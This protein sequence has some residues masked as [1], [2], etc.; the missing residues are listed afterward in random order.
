GPAPRAR[1]SPGRASPCASGGRRR[2]RRMRGGAS[3]NRG[4]GTHG[5]RD[6]TDPA[7]LAL[8]IL[9]AFWPESLHDTIA[10]ELGLDLD[11]ISRLPATRMRD[12]SF[13]PA[14]LR[15]YERRC[16][17]CGF[18]AT[19]GD[20]LIGIDAAHIHFK[21]EGGPDVVTNGLALCSLHHKAFDLGAIGVSH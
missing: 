6:R 14:I 20:A 12:P 16:V 19:L 3:V 2:G 4:G 1:S 13:R 7:D 21:V 11:R 18:R 17:V 9:H 10:A 15:A 5:E 8:H